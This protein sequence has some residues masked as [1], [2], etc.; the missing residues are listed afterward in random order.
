[1]GNKR[2]KRYM[3]S[4]G[5][6]MVLHKTGFQQITEK[7]WDNAEIRVSSGT[8]TGPKTKQKVRETVSRAISDGSVPKQWR[9]G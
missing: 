1:M 6:T 3:H 5:K 8:A 9:L 7:G 2:W 4:A